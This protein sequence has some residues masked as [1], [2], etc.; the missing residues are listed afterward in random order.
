MKILFKLPISK[1]K[2]T[3]FVFNTENEKDKEILTSEKQKKHDAKQVHDL[4]ENIIKTVNY[5]SK[6]EFYF[7]NK[8]GA[9]WDSNDTLKEKIAKLEQKVSGNYVDYSLNK[10]DLVEDARN[11]LI[12]LRNQYVEL[13]KYIGYE[14]TDKEI[15]KSY[16]DRHLNGNFEDLLENK[17]K[18]DAFLRFLI[19]GLYSI[20]G[21]SSTPNWEK[22]NIELLEMAMEELI[23]V[24]E[25]E[26]GKS[27]LGGRILDRRHD[28][29][30]ILE[31]FREKEGGTPINH[32]R[33][34]AKLLV[35]LKN[36]TK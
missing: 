26:Y 6:G 21:F 27:W 12:S 1:G 35:H 29:P 11:S 10:Q 9:D 16:I 32:V 28:D 5:V 17:E 18:L 4:Q 34:I 20:R 31:R 8:I 36:L 2:N 22:N 3:K 13:N 33:N 19:Q 25:G 30:N 7:N 24:F 14:D 15:F 23:E